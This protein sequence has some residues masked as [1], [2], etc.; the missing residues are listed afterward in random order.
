LYS[1]SLIC[2]N[3]WT[4]RNGAPA[5]IAAAELPELAAAYVNAS[6][7]GRKIGTMEPPDFKAG[8]AFVLP[9]GH[10]MSEQPL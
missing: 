7:D 3:L 2:K 6:G 10:L 9:D 8:A 1:R 4:V 5:S